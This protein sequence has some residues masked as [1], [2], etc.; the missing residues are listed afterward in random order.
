MYQNFITP[1]GEEALRKHKYVAGAYT[2]LDNFLNPYWV[3]LTELL[4]LWMAPNLVT[5]TGFCILLSG[6]LLI[7]LTKN[8]YSGESPAFAY[9]YAAVALLVYMTFDAM[10]GKQARR[11][12]HSTPLGQIMDHGCDCVGSIFMI[13]SLYSALD[14]NGDSVTC[15]LTVVAVLQV[16][17]VPQFAEYFTHVLLTSKGVFGVTESEFI[18]AG[19]VASGG[20]IGPSFFNTVLPVVG[21][22]LNFLVVLLAFLGSLVWAVAIIIDAYEKADDKGKVVRYLITP[23]SYYVLA[24]ILFFSPLKKHSDALLFTFLF[25]YCAIT[26]KMI[27]SSLTRV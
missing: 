27:V 9:L 1:A 25:C 19:L 13:Y 12:G 11:I 10:D 7:F 21:V 18:M 8:P 20:L 16:F 5:F 2:P 14:V 6:S 26:L 24:T 4:P 23:L 17:F 15:Y 3:K 22:K